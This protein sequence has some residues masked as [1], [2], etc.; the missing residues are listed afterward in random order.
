[1][2]TICILIVPSYQ[3]VST[4]LNCI[5]V[6]K[7]KKSVQVTTKHGYII[8]M[9]VDARMLGCLRLWLLPSGEDTNL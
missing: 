8:L 9:L 2:S 4:A 3:L 1:M 6:R 5:Y 7:R